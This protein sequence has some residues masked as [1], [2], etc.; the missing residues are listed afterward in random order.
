MAVKKKTK[1]QTT[2]FNTQHKKKSENKD[3]KN[4][5]ELQFLYE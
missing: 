5:S 3:N 4:V 2:S 1:R